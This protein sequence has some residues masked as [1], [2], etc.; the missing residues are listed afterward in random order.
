MEHVDDHAPLVVTT[1]DS[2]PVRVVTLNRPERKNVLN[3]A[4]V[5]RLVLEIET[6]AKDRSAA[7][8]LTGSGDCF[9][10][11]GDLTEISSIAD[12]QGALGVTEMIYGHF[13]KLFHAV[14]DSPIPVV[15][16]INGPAL[17][18][19]FDLALCADLRLAS[20]SAAFASS[21]I[22]VGLVPGMA[23]AYQLSRIVGMGR[24]AE[25]LLFGRQILADEALSWGLV[26]RVFPDDNLIEASLEF[27]SRLGSFSRAAISHTK[28]AL[29]RANSF[30]LDTEL[31]A[32]RGVQGGLLTSIEFQQAA[33]RFR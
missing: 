32:L 24:A 14:S 16:A 11:G 8:L 4:L 26:N 9:C 19:G 1:Y 13:H 30:G 3:I 5:D 12:E 28:Q 23:G 29:R 27:V 7:L 6:A 2:E 31:A 18:A 17:G 20:E 15:A 21:W 22:K 10:A 25:A 33:Q